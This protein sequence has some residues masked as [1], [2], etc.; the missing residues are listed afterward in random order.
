MVPWKAAG[1]AFP[2]V[3][4]SPHAHRV[5][6]GLRL[7]DRRHPRSEFC[8]ATSIPAFVGA[9]LC[10]EEANGSCKDRLCVGFALASS[11]LTGLLPLVLGEA[12]AR[13]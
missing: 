2:G 1:D 8:C 3:L 10:L 9:R 5:D 6:A 7:R 13:P 12:A 4:R 11:A